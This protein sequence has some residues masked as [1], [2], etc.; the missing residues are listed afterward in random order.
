LRNIVFCHQLL[1]WKLS[2]V[3]NLLSEYFSC[4]RAAVM[5]RVIQHAPPTPPT[6]FF[7]F[8]FFSFFFLCRA[9]QEEIDQKLAC[10]ATDRWVQDRLS[11][12]VVIDP[13]KMA[14]C[15]PIPMAS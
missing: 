10:S 6:L 9:F 4:H 11:V 7:S 1:E 15:Q 14:R 12:V 13:V 5:R 8:L 2:V 3:Y